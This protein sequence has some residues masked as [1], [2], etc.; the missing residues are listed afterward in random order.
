[1]W[2]LMKLEL[3]KVH[4]KKYVLISALLILLSMYFVCV[5]LNDTSGS[6]DTYESTF[7]VIELIFAFVFIIFFSVLN[8]SI[9]ISEYNNKTI[10]IMFTYP[11]N[12][13]KII[14]VKLMLNTLFITASLAAGYIACCTFVV[15]VDKRFDLLAGEFSPSM[16]SGWISAAALTIVAFNAW[17]IC[18][19]VVGM[20]KKSVSMTIVSSMIFVFLRQVLITATDNNHESPMLVLGLVIVT[21]AAVAG[22]FR[23]HSY[24]SLPS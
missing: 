14:A 16:I 23:T 21:L 6:Q 17:G 13:K 2:R 20:W 24:S 4:F 1:M 5:S 9:I 12:R 11:V 8:S 18:T 19:F 7:R 22:V 15:A 3:K 10:L